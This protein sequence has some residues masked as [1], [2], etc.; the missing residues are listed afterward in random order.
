[1]VFFFT[2]FLYTQVVITNLD[3]DD[4]LM[5]ISSQIQSKARYQILHPFYQLK[6][7]FSSYISQRVNLQ[8]EFFFSYMK[9][10]IYYFGEPYPLSKYVIL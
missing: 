2:W 8:H 7:F 5:I 10:N 6:C 4:K 1:M 3:I 9:L